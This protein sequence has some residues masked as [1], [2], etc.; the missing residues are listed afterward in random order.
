[1][2]WKPSNLSATEARA[3]DLIEKAPA[4]GKHA[5]R[6][7]LFHIERAHALQE[8]DP[9]MALFRSITGEEEAVRAIFDSLQRR[10]YPNARRLNWQDHKHKAAVVP[11]LRAVADLINKAGFAGRVPQ[12]VEI[13]IG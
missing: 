10:D 13:G 8:V 3:W 5:A 12:A 2:P 11:F 1:M 7:A 6:N 9:E 4:P